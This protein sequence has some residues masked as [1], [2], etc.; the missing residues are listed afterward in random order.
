LDS[1]RSFMAMMYVCWRRV[2][3]L[4]ETLS[5][6]DSSSA[7]VGVRVLLRR[8]LDLFADLA[9]LLLGEWDRM[10]DG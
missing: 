10:G 6:G 5:L 7:Q 1:E 9:A 3:M 8:D 4:T 2:N